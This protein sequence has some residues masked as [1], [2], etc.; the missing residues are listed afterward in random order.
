MFNEV[1]FN[2]V[3]VP[4]D[5]VVGPVDGGWTVARSTLGNERV[6]IGGGAGN[7]FTLDVL[8]IY[9]NHGAGV[10]GAATAVGKHVAE[11]QTLRVVNLRAAERAVAGGEPGP[12][13]NITKLISAEHLQH[14]ADLGLQLAG[15]D[16][17]TLAGTGGAIVGKC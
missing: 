2:D 13:G 16:V 17:A 1:F 12:E 4:D 15:A 8:D 5:D 3:F 14:A 11:G 10:D 9:R 7:M 6:S